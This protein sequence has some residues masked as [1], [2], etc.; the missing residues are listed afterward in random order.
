MRRRPIQCLG[1]LEF[2]WAISPSCWYKHSSRV[3]VSMMKLNSEWSKGW[4]ATLDYKC[5]ALLSCWCF[6]KPL[7]VSPCTTTLPVIIGWCVHS[8][9]TS[10][11]HSNGMLHLHNFNEDFTFA[12]DSVN[13]EC[14]GVYQVKSHII[15]QILTT[16]L[17]QRCQPGLFLRPFF[18]SWTCKYWE[19]LLCA[20][21]TLVASNHKCRAYCTPF[22]TT[23]PF[24]R[25]EKQNMRFLHESL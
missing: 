5:T 14:A 23:R 4:G 9:S 25:W 10:M 1:Q 2:D 22:R 17:S 19:T 18:V 8:A 16:F 20:Q 7:L 12:L 6:F 21:L 24:P 15:T 13:T 3:C 11:E